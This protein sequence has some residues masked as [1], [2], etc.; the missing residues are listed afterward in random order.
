M[1]DILIHIGDMRVILKH[2]NGDKGLGCQG[3]SLADLDGNRA[4]FQNMPLQIKKLQAFKKCILL[5]AGIVKHADVAGMIR[6]HAENLAERANYMVSHHLSFSERGM[7]DL[8]SISRAVVKSYQYA[9]EARQHGNMDAVRKVRQYEDE[10]D[11][12]EEEMRE[13]HIERL[14]SGK[15]VPSAGVVFLDIITNL[16]RVS[17]HAYNLAGYVKNEL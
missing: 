14:S 8:R 16:E 3:V 4:G 17:D 9:I 7:E 2:G 5:V 6:D 15:C 11:N 12:M 13:E 10:V 1:C